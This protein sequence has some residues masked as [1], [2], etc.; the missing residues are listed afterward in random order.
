[1]VIADLFLAGIGA[2]LFAMALIPG[3]VPGMVI[4]ILLVMAGAGFLLADLSRRQAAWRLL[5]RPQSSWVSRGTIG[6]LSFAVLAAAHIVNLVIRSDNWTSL[7]APWVAGQTGSMVL[8]IL[9]GV[10]ALFVASYTGFLL[11][12]M[13]AIPLWNSAYIP[14]LFLV[15]ALLGGLGL[16][17]LFPLNWNMLPWALSLMQDLG[18]VLVVI[19][20]FLLLAVIG[21]THSATTRESVRLFTHGALRPHFMIG[22]FGIGLIVPLIL[23]AL[24]RV[25]AGSVVLMPAAGALLVIGMFLSRYII[26]KA[27]MHVSPV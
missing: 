7:G 14:A 5:A 25:G 10:A 1:M 26:T 3:F 18:I 2:G 22:L 23:L 21:L 27:G 6:N 15:S 9:A 4:G 17:Y 20:L 12:N 24:V 13:R 8:A 16:V 11:G 19:E